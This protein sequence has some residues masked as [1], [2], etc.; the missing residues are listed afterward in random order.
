[1]DKT[2]E[3]LFEIIATL[4][5]KQKKA[6]IAFVEGLIK[7]QFADFGEDRIDLGDLDF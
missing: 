2:D 5:Q 3:R 4:D 1:M 6:A 7:E